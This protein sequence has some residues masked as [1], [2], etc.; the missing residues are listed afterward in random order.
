MSRSVPSKNILSEIFYRKQCGIRANIL[1]NQR[2]LKQLVFSWIFGLLHNPSQRPT[3]KFQV[4][5]TTQTTVG[6]FCKVDY[7]RVFNHI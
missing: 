4:P 7:I 3:L 1:S 6:T 2:K 5:N